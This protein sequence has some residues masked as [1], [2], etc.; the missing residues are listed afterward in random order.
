ME[1]TI[2]QRGARSLVY[3]GYK[4][5]I[6]RRGRDGR[7]FWRC[8]KG[9]KLKWWDDYNGRWRQQEILIIT[10]Q[11]LQS[12]LEAEKITTT[13]KRKAMESAQPIPT[14]YLNELAS[15]ADMREIAAKLPTFQ[16]ARSSLY[17][18]RRKRL[19]CM[20]QSRTEVH[21]ENEWAE[22]ID[23]KRFLL[24][25]DGDDKKIIIFAT[26]NRRQHEASCRGR[27]SLFWWNF[28]HMPRNLL[29]DLHCPCLQKWP[30][31]ST[32]LL[33]STRQ[34]SQF[35]SADLYS[36]KLSKLQICPFQLQPSRDVINITANV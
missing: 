4:Y 13:I 35:L 5:V 28:P 11:M 22:S 12:W 16:F 34:D 33:P 17:R 24:V 2:T 21:F 8:G 31:V 30:T 10:H 23:G 14:L 26:G 29:S 6:N 32:C 19:P 15:R 7:I 18:A 9:Q 3:Q 25:E 1:F 27:D 36:S 20:P